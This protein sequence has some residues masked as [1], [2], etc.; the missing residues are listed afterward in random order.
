MITCGADVDL[1]PFV[2]MGQV[3]G[4]V[5]M[6]L[7]MILC[8]SGMVNFRRPFSGRIYFALYPRI[9]QEGCQRT[10]VE[11]ERPSFVEK[12]G[13]LSEIGNPGSTIG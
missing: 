9:P 10:T 12:H 2:D 4:S 11:R 13:L 3:C 1:F 5:D 6:D 7:I 8:T